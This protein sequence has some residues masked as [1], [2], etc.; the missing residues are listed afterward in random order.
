MNTR[1][2][3]LSLHPVNSPIEAAF[4]Y[5]GREARDYSVP[6]SLLLLE[7]LLCFWFIAFELELS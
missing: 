7:N 4:Q 6:N 2:I 3:P 5:S 1:A